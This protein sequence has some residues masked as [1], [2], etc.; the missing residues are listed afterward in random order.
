MFSKPALLLKNVSVQLQN[1]NTGIIIDGSPQWWTYRGIII[2]IDI[3][4]LK[5][6]SQIGMLIQIGAESQP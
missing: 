5:I 4:H 2:A 6:Q 3:K 1:L